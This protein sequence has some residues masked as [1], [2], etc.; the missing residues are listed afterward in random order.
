MRCLRVRYEDLVLHP[1][2]VIAKVLTFLDLP[3]NSSVLS[4]HTMINQPGGVRVS[5]MERSSDQIIQPVHTKA[6]TEWVGTFPS[7]LLSQMG[8]VAPML[9]QLGY[10]P[11]ENPPKYGQADPEILNNTREV[12]LNKEYWKVRSEQMLRAMKKPETVY[13]EQPS[14]YEA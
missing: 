3:W 2:N 5:V 12:L 1:R 7:K 4:H 11:E 6:L 10:N 14:Q 9:R 13:N 8:E